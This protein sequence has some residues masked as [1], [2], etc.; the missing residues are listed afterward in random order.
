MHIHYKAFYR[1]LLPRT[2]V[3]KG[4]MSYDE[5]ILTFFQW[6]YIPFLSVFKANVKIYFVYGKG[7]ST[8][9]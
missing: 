6:L 4:E 7:L 5:L 2:N 9:R 8:S 3:T 1:R